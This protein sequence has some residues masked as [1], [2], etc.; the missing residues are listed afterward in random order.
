M[1]HEEKVFTAPDFEKPGKQVSFETEEYAL[2]Y[3]A[4]HAIK[5]LNA[6]LKVNGIR[7]AEEQAEAAKRAIENT[8][9]E[10]LECLVDAI[11]S[12]IYSDD[13]NYRAKS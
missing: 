10:L 8:P 7:G 9:I 1:I 5:K 4:F 2:N 3:V 12:F 6:D 13:P 11:S